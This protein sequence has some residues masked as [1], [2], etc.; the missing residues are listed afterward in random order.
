MLENNYQ[1]YEN[2]L[3]EYYTWQNSIHSQCSLNV[4]SVCGK[5]E[6]GI[7]Y[8]SKRSQACQSCIDNIASHKKLIKDF[9]F[10]KTIR[11][12][13]VNSQ[14]IPFLISLSDEDKYDFLFR[15]LDF[16]DHLSLKEALELVREFI[17]LFQIPTDT[18]YFYDTFFPAFLQEFTTDPNLLP[19]WCADIPIGFQDVKKPGEMVHY[20]D[21]I[22]ILHQQPVLKKKKA[23]KLFTLTWGRE[24]IYS[25]ARAG[26]G[27][28][29]EF[30]EQYQGTVV[31]TSNRIIPLHSDGSSPFIFLIARISSVKILSSGIEITLDGHDRPYQLIGLND[32]RGQNIGFCVMHLV[33]KGTQIVSLVE[34]S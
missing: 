22:T 34:N 20:I 7:P 21:I 4:C 28:D 9:L 13:K 5:H 23:G 14:E 8:V 31:I 30:F 12:E 3:R 17:A 11:H 29:F 2:A 27:T 24:Q 10:N 15:L 6:K 1:A 19:V 33:K 18:P 25:H 32:K 26:E 16:H